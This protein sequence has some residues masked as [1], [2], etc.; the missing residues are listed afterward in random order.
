MTSPANHHKWLL[1]EN[2]F[3]DAENMWKSI[4]KKHKGKAVEV[5]EKDPAIPNPVSN[6]YMWASTVM[7]DNTVLSQDQLARNAVRAARA[8]LLSKDSQPN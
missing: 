7:D 3:A 8:Q 2:G 4:E 1:A 6:L 5:F